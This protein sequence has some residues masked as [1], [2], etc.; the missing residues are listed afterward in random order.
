MIPENP[1]AKQLRYGRSEGYESRSQRRLKYDLGIDASAAEAI[2]HLRSQVIE[3]QAQVQRLETELSVHDANQQIRLA[4]YR[5]AYYEATW[6]E[7]EFQE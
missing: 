7:V 2:L 3:L 6:I 1:S 4:R 5:E